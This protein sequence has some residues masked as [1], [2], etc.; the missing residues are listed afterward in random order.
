MSI[1]ITAVGAALASIVLAHDC[2]AEFFLTAPAKL[3]SHAVDSSVQISLQ[4]NPETGFALTLDEDQI[5]DLQTDIEDDS[6]GRFYGGWVDDEPTIT[7]WVRPGSTQGSYLIDIDAPDW[8]VLRVEIASDETI[9]ATVCRCSAVGPTATTCPSMKDCD[10]SKSCGSANIARNATRMLRPSSRLDF[11]RWTR[12]TPRPSR[13]PV[14][15]HRR[16]R[17]PGP[18]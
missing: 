5:S 10:S 2:R 6:N 15:G 16:A 7:G 1:R 3:L 18:A 11:P 14:P 4:W 8:E 9:S 12:S 17:A 13:R